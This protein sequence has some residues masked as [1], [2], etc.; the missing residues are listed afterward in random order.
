MQTQVQVHTATGTRR[1]RRQLAG[2][3]WR[4]DTTQ[5]RAKHGEAQRWSVGGDEGEGEG[6]SEDGREQADGAM[7][8]IRMNAWAGFAA[9]CRG[10]DADTSL[11]AD[12][13]PLRAVLPPYEWSL[14][15]GGYF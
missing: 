14:F 3:G 7:N 12:H 9:T 4:S 2:A 15:G 10:R 13:W 11:M 8:G 5:S 6:E 1:R